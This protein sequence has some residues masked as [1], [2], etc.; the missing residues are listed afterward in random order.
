MRATSKA[1]ET[2]KVIIL[3]AGHFIHDTYPAFLAPLIPLLKQKLGLSNTLAGTLATFLRSS[4][5]VQPFIGYLA[6]RISARWLVVLAPA[7]TALFMSFLGAA[8]SYVF[9]VPLLILTGL[10]HAAYHA[11]APAMIAHVSGER[12]GAGMSLFMMGG[13]LGRAAGPLVIVAAVRW[14]GLEHSYVTAIPGLLATAAMA[15]TLG[16]APPPPK[17]DD[18]FALRTVL[19]ERRRPL[20]FLSAFIFIR[21]LVVGSVTVFIPAYLTTRG[22]TVAQ[23][24]AGYALFELAGAGGALGGGT[25]SDRA[26]RRRTLIAGQVL[27]VAP[28][29]ALAAGPQ[30]WI[31]PLLAVTGALVFSGTPVILALVQELLPEARSTASGLYFSLNY[32]SAGLAAILFGVAADTL[33]MQR[34]FTL[35]AFVPILTLPFALVLPARPAPSKP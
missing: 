4:S 28:F 2:G 23:A 25:F 17:Q 8:P 3:S 5:L 34:A 1:F 21:A 32:L 29:Y 10:S 14:F 27:V 20:A 30:E 26:G 19:S 31:A 33:G 11:P 7:A 6:D 24:A 15:K 22:M 18:G 35:L 9:M 12:V 16:P 13:E